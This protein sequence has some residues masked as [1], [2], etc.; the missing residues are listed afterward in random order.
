M[1]RRESVDSRPV[2]VVGCKVSN[3]YSIEVETDIAGW[4]VYKAL[5][6]LV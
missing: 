6:F 2:N 1:C 5:C 4:M 3:M